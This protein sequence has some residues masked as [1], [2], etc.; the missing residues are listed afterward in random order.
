VK[1]QILCLQAMSRHSNSRTNSITMTVKIRQRKSGSVLPT[2]RWLTGGRRTGPAFPEFAKYRLEGPCKGLVKAG[3]VESQTSEMVSEMS[4][5]PWSPSCY[6]AEQADLD[7]LSWPVE[8]A[9]ASTATTGPPL[10]DRKGSCQ[11]SGGL[12]SDSHAACG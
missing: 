7:E 5:C 6:F 11:E 9:L 4:P 1:H 10:P 12:T 2:L 3:Q 8:F